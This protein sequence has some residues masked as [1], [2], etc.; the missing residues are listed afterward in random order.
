MYEFDKT[1]H[2][3]TQSCRNRFCM[4]FCILSCAATI[5]ETIQTKFD[6]IIQNF[7]GCLDGTIN[8]KCNNNIIKKQKLDINLSS[9]FLSSH[10]I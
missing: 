4:I 5:V 8:N 10:M 6:K 7:F 3:N 2:N 9:S 1:R